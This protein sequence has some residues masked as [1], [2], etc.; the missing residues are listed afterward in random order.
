MHKNALAATVLSLLI[1]GAALAPRAQDGA[2]APALSQPYVHLYA[3]AQGVSHFKD[4][5]LVIKPGAS[6]PAP[7]AISQSGGATLLALRRGQ[8]EDWHRAPRRMYLV[9]L[10]GMSQVTVGDGEVRRFGP[11]SLLLMDDTMGKG[12]IT[13]AVG[14]EDHVAL[15]VPAPAP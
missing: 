1:S 5:V 13:Q 2:A 11:G 4:E 15:T 10:K 8:K 6:G 3:D 9:A 14:S 12:H 7:L